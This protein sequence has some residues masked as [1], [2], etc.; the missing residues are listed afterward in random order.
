MVGAHDHDM[1]PGGTD[2]EMAVARDRADRRCDGPRGD[3]GTGG[4]PCPSAT[5]ELFV[6]SEAAEP[7]FTATGDQ[8]FVFKPFTVSPKQAKSTRTA[9][10]PEW[11]AQSLIAEVRYSGCTATAKLG[12]IGEVELKARF[13]AP[14]DLDFNANGFVEAGVGGKHQ[15]GDSKVR[16]RSKSR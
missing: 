10:T 6:G 11:P 14:V 3:T 7:R 16:G 8:E 1:H 4:Q 2:D 15:M 12:A 5:Q 9:L 13:A